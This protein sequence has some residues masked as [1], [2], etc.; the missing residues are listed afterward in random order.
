MRCV[1]LPGGGPGNPAFG[2]VGLAFSSYWHVD[3]FVS[4]V[5]ATD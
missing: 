4:F 3:A 2:A 1:F 5:Q